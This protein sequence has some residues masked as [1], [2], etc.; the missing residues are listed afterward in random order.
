MSPGEASYHLL[1]DQV[2]RTYEFHADPSKRIGTGWESIDPLI[3]GGIAPGE[4]FYILGRSH[5]GKSMFLLN[6]IRNNQASPSILFTIEMPEH[7]AITRLTAMVMAQDHDLIQRQMRNNHLAWEANPLL[8][9]DTFIVDD[10]VSFAAMTEVIEKIKHDY[11]EELWPRFVCLDYLELVR[12]DG[13]RKEGYERA[14]VLARDLKAWSKAMQLPVF[15]VHQ[16][17]MTRKRWESVDE[18]SARGAGYTEADVVMG[19][20]HPASDPKV[21]HDRDTWQTFKAQVIKNRISGA[22]SEQ[23]TFK[24]NTSLTLD[25]PV[26]LDRMTMGLV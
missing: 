18:N 14:E 11:F 5:T 8:N 2:K 1:S 19:V 3:L 4:V 21:N 20:W 7:Q 10:S 9:Y 13:S 22:L 12:T 15:V 25:D 17:N 26:T 23:L 6:V 24:L 16:S